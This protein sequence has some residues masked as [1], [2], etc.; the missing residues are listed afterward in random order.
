M[1]A[2]YADEIKPLEVNLERHMEHLREQPGVDVPIWRDRIHN[3]F[4][5]DNYSMTGLEDMDWDEGVDKVKDA[6]KRLR[7]RDDFRAKQ[8]LLKVTVAKKPP[9]AYGKSSLPVS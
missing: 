7:K 5:W 1:V 9:R 8:D 3:S 6:Q 2:L 4:I